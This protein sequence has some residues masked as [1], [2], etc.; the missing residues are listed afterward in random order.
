MFPDIDPAMLIFQSFLNAQVEDPK[1]CTAKI[2][3]TD[4]PVLEA[5]LQFAH[6]V[7]TQNNAELETYKQAIISQIETI[8]L[9]ADA[10]L[11]TTFPISMEGHE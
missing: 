10:C 8:V 9:P 3:G 2:L 11:R 1:E 7:D 4:T 6:R 5:V